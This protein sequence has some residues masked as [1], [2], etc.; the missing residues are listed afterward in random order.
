MS[1]IATPLVG[2]T[3][4]ETWFGS[5]TEFVFLIVA[6]AVAG[7]FAL[8]QTWAAFAASVTLLDPLGDYWNCVIAVLGAVTV[9]LVIK[10]LILGVKGKDDVAL[11]LQLVIIGV[12]GWAVANFLA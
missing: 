1:S 9:G 6:T 3:K 8:Y 7:G 5:L 12:L 2:D 11:P 10:H 4:S